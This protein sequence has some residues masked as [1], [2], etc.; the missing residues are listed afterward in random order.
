MHCPSSAP[1]LNLLTG[2]TGASQGDPRRRPGPAHGQQGVYQVVR[3]GADKATVST[4]STPPAADRVLEET[5]SI[6]KAQI[7]LRREILKRQRPR[8]RQQPAGHRPSPVLK[9]L[10]A[11]LA[12]VPR[13]DRNAVQLR[14]GQQ[15]ACSIASSPPRRRSLPAGTPR[16]ESS[17]SSKKASRPPPHGGSLERPLSGTGRSGRRIS[18]P[19]KTGA[20]EAEKRVLANAEK[21]YAAAMSTSPIQLWPGNLQPETPARHKKNVEELARYGSR[22]R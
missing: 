8:V 11:E 9:Q 3:H 4:S 16:S 14:P 17:A 10:R 12:L 5:A 18:S 22:S 7:I 13:P 15:P 2:E 6:L 1:G 19:V 21:L 20:L